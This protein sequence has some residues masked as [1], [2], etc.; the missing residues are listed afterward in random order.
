VRPAGALQLW[1]AAALVAGAAHAGVATEHE[2]L[3]VASDPFTAAPAEQR[4][5]VVFSTAT[6][7]ARVPIEIWRKG[8]DLALVRFLAAKDRG[9]FVVRRD[10]QFFFLSP[11]AAKPVRLAP[12]LA[13]AGG[14][15]LD[16]LL[17]VRPSRDYAI[18]RVAERAG[19]VTFDL[20]ARAEGT[21]SPRLRWVVDRQRRRP[22]RAEFRAADERVERLIEFTGWRE[23]RR[24]EPT[25]LIAKEIGRG[26]VPLEVELVELE[27]REVPAAL[28]EL[29]DGAARAAL[30]EPELTR[31]GAE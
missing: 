20:V 24:L 17:A 19:V 27:A 10:D 6:S 13:P 11:G 5:L 28:F 25:T 18:E 9:K 31:P 7:K 21:P 16:A 14:A 26:G 1:G 30:P 15:A 23:G 22:L 29:D 3:L 8:D 4:A 2:K 12:A